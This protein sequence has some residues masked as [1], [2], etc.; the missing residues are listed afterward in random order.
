[1]KGKVVGIVSDDLLRA[2]ERACARRTSRWDG[3]EQLAVRGDLHFVAEGNC[4]QL[5][6]IS[7]SI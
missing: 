4:F 6:S 5:K 7:F 1:M 2:V 3:S